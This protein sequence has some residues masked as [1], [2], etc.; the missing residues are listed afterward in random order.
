MAIN[1][2]RHTGAIASSQA[3]EI[4]VM[5]ILAEG[6]PGTNRPHKVYKLYSNTS[7]FLNL[8]TSSWFF[9]YVIRIHVLLS[10]QMMINLPKTHIHFPMN[11]C[12]QDELY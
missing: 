7:Y 1:C 6:I 8:L 10:F 12:I 4:Y 9:F 2:V 5:D 11:F 3:V